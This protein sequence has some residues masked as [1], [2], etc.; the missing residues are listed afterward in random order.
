MFRNRPLI[1]VLLAALAGI[2]LPGICVG[3]GGPKNVLLVVNDNSPIS[4]SIAAYYQQKRGIPAKNVCH[5]RC[6]TS[7]Y[8]S[9]SDCE[10]NIVAPI[11]DYINNT[12]GLHDRIDYIVLT[13][14]IPLG[15]H[16]DDVAFSGPLSVNSILTCVGEPTIK[17]VIQN[18][19]GPTANPPAPVQYFTHKLDFNGKHFYAVTRLDARTEADIRRMI[20]DSL[21]AQ[22]RNGLFILDGAS[23]GYAQYMLVND[24]IRT[25]NNALFNAGWQTYY[26]NVTFDSRINEF[27]GGQ[28]GVMGYFGWGSAEASFSYSLYTSNYFAPGSIA[29]TVVSSSGRTFTDPWMPGTQS[30]IVD[31]IAQGASAVNGFVSEPFVTVATYPTILFDRY[32]QGYNVA[33]S[34]LAATPCIYWKSVVSGDPLMAPYATPPIVSITSPNPEKV[35]HGMVTIAVEA[36]D[37]SGIAKVEFYIDDNLVAT[38]TSPPYQYIWDTTT[39]ADGA[40]VI[41][42]IAYENSSVY[43]QG[44]AKLDIQVVNTVLDVP[45]IGDISS[46]QEGRLVRLSNKPVIAGSDAFTDCIWICESDRSTGI[47]VSGN[48]EALTGSLVT[49]TGEVQVVGGQKLIQAYVFESRGSNSAPPPLGMPNLYVGNRGGGMGLLYEDLLQGL[50]NAGL[51]VKTWGKVTQVGTEWFNISDGTLPKLSGELTVSL[52]NLRNPIPKP[53]VGSYVTVTGVCALALE[54]GQLKPQIRPRFASDIV[55]DIPLEVYTSPIGTVRQGANLISIPAISTT[56]KPEQVF[57][58][59]PIDGLLAHWDNF[60]KSFVIYDSYQSYTFPG[61]RLGLGLCLLSSQNHTIAFEGLGNYEPRADFWIGLPNTGYHMIGHPFNFIV[62]VNS[63]LVSNGKSVISVE[64]AA[65]YGWIEP[66][67]YFW[68]NVRSEYG[69]VDIGFGNICILEPWRGY[70]MKTYHPNLALIIPFAPS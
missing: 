62:D 61:I 8:T 68:D 22:P 23:S 24:R 36:S 37:A 11:R 40:H 9:K 34:F 65:D 47:Q 31:L 30:L 52:S 32:L 6:S 29:D 54:A 66:C 33:E 17:D 15:A 69:A 60:T 50:S 67:L 70:W 58:G 21:A 28:Q 16:Y 13:K 7:E 39:V 38:Q 10:N 5:I 41:E 2:C 55:C 18:P 20:D 59:I 44:M 27:V 25:A 3:G 64:T 43:T 14:G 26:D 48:C 1:S 42:A 57:A 49:V 45:A 51:L 46:L 12:P 56:S 63:C 19:Y 4:Q 35:A 53:P